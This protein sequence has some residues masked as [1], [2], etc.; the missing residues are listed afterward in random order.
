MRRSPARRVRLRHLGTLAAAV[1]AVGT[2]AATTGAAAP[3][4]VQHTHA[5]HQRWVSTWSASSTQGPADTATCPAHSG[6]TDGTVRDVVVP[7]AGGD[8]AR[9]RLTNLF[10]DRPLRV[11]RASIAVRDSGSSVVASTLRT[12]RFHGRTSVTIDPGDLAGSDPVSLPVRAGQALVVSL[13]FP[14]AT[15]PATQH[16]LALQDGYVSP[17]DH[18]GTATAGAARTVNCWTFADRVDVTPARRVTGTLV[19]LGD[20]ITDGSHST[21]NANRRWPDDLNR[22]LQARHGPI[23]SVANAGISGNEVLVDR[24]PV[25]FGPSAL[26]RLDRDVLSVPGARDVILLEGINDIGA[27]SATGTSIIAGDKQIIAR[28]HHQGLRIFGATLTAFG[29]SNPQYGGDYG[30]AYGER[31]R[32]AVNHWIR[33]GHAFDGVIDFDKATADP[34]NPQQMAPAYDSGDH[35]HPGDAGYQR[36]AD[37]IKIS[38]LLRTK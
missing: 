24:V 19:T 2:A 5:A 33:T 17:G 25:T 15:G 31:Q 9:V 34:S 14:D 27:A 29:G 20:S 13:Y 26:H 12:L 10:G 35:L 1:A 3:S 11:G 30:T 23:L 37:S 7:S 21:P 8:H 22:R 36:M 32:E 38:A 6:V 28:A 4:T 18:T 16:P